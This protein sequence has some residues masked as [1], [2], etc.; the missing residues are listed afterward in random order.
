MVDV[1]LTYMKEKEW[2]V[3]LNEAQGN[4][5]PEVVK[6]RYANVPEQWQEF[7]QKVRCMVSVDETTWFLGAEDFELQGDK[8]FRWNEWELMS[9]EWAEGD[10]EWEKEI[11]NFWDGHLPIVMS[12][13]NGYSYYAICMKDGSVVRGSEPEFEECEVVADSFMNFVDKI[14][15]DG[16]Q[17]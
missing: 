5:L 15:E 11:K 3:R 7:V 10:T 4:S 13:R 16:L 6:S 14:M 1:F 12:V 8:A 9:L 2:D 17:L